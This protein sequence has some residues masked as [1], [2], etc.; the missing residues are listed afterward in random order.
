MRRVIAFIL[1][2]LSAGYSLSHATPRSDFDRGNQFFQ[3][4]AYDS[5]IA[6]YSSIER[7]GLESAEL[8]FNLGNAYF[9]KGD[10]GHAVLY[11]MRARRLKPGDDDIAVNLAFAKGY[12]R[13]QMEGVQLNPV[14]SLTENVLGPY[15]LNLLA[16]ISSALFIVLIL[17]LAARF[18]S[19]FR[20]EWL[21]GA[22]TICSILLV[23]SVFATTFKYRHDYVTKRGVVV[24]EDCPVQSGPTDQTATE[25]HGAPGLVVEIIGR[26]SDYV[27]VVFE[28][29][30]Q[31]WVRYDKIETI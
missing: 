21:R 19:A 26:S 1:L 5:A 15:R 10:L 9:K 11:Y 25:L 27:Q 16:W 22:I 13:I 2:A 17:L 24:A 20:H 7:Q 29:K 18:G 12:T 3:E 8:Y 30:R 4:K 23:M 28:N 31:G 6:V 14:Y